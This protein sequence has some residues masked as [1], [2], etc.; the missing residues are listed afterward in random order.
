MTYVHITLDKI[1]NNQY[2]IYSNHNDE[3]APIRLVAPLLR[4]KKM[5]N[6]TIIVGEDLL[7]T[8]DTEPMR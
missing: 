6:G 4:S 2:F 1:K 7:G 8:I 3:G 5:F